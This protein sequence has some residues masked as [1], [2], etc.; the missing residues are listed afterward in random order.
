MKEFLRQV[1]NKSITVFSAVCI[2]V[3]CNFCP[4]IVSAN[5]GYTVHMYQTYENVDDLSAGHSFRNGLEGD[6]D[7]TSFADGDTYLGLD[8]VFRVLPTTAAKGS[9]AISIGDGFELNSLPENTYVETE[10]DMAFNMFGGTANVN[11]GLAADSWDTANAYLK[12]SN[13]YKLRV[14]D[15]GTVV[16]TLEQNMFHRIKLVMRSVED[17]GV[18]KW[19]LCSLKAD[20]AE[21]LKGEVIARAV[22]YKYIVAR[23]GTEPK[24]AEGDEIT[25]CMCFDNIS[26][27]SY[28]SES[29]LSP[30]PDRYALLNRIKSVKERI[31]AED[32]TVSAGK[33]AELTGR[34]LDE[35]EVFRDTEGDI[36]ASNARID[37]VEEEISAYKQMAET[38]EKLYVAD[39]YIDRESLGGADSVT[40]GVPV[41][42]SESGEVSYKALA[43]LYKSNDKL[44]SDELVQ[45][46]PVAQLTV[47][48]GQKGVLEH[49]FDISGCTEE[50]K[51]GLSVKLIPFSE[52]SD[53]TDGIPRYF[54][55]FGSSKPI[56]SSYSFVD[57][58]NVS[59]A[60]M[61]DTTQKLVFALKG[62]AGK[63]ASLLVL[64]KDKTDISGGLPESVEYYNTAKFDESGR[65][66]FEVLPSPPETGNY[67]YIINCE[68][69][70]KPVSNSVYYVDL[71]EVKA[72]I[73]SIKRN[74][75][76]EELDKYKNILFV[77]TDVYRNAVNSTVDISAALSDVLEEKDY[78]EFTVNE[79]SAAF[80]SKL[81][82]IYKFNTVSSTDDVK[83]CINEYSDRLSECGG[84]KELTK[85]QVQRACELIYGDRMRMITEDKINSVI[86][87]AVNA[88]KT[89][90]GDSGNRR[91]GGGSGGSGSGSGGMWIGS[92]PKDAAEDGS[93]KQT[94][95]EKAQ[96]LFGDIDDVE[97]AKTAI[98]SFALRGYI[99]GRRDGE[100][101]PN[102]NVTREEFVKMAVG[103]L[104]FAPEGDC[105]FEDADKNAWYYSYI[106]AGVSH[107]IVNGISESIFGVGRLITRE[108]M[109]VIIYR[110]AKS[111][112]IA[113]TSDGV[114]IEFADESLISGYAREAVIEAAKSGIVNG[115][116][117]NYFE[118]KKSATRAE[119]VKMLY[120]L[121]KLGEGGR[122]AE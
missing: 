71:E 55:F 31:S 73:D 84:F 98:M 75:S 63:N 106:A 28:V 19:A 64:K 118:P 21:L 108:D 95:M 111:A 56:D 36:A 67:Q 45:M 1:I 2:A 74:P 61:E 59:A 27:T 120:E 4:F 54:S 69:Y 82:M 102:D 121:S 49:T 58:V 44:L 104:G 37:S 105:E 86:K 112:G 48:A 117:D 25:D 92:G 43:L 62:S 103:V 3:S 11:I 22:D 16:K 23:Y 6:I 53:I 17:A 46:S 12:L 99:N 109:A 100:F 76:A 33:K 122:S 89:S 116:G 114:Y 29:G 38:S 110:A 77:D 68:D 80:L 115:T 41:Y 79:F 10:F 60:V 97:W 14:L 39:A 83:I 107:G 52:I 34:L 113:L 20:G 119:A 35:V 26:V 96:E 101:A 18:K 94:V 24:P 66:V 57:T 13:G 5:E 30:V 8:S 9:V 15:D 47:P 42:A 70:D 87:S 93:E 72:A 65:A 40:V 7:T 91:P 88:A 81:D 90:E 50:E 78:T 32:F 85:K 51:A